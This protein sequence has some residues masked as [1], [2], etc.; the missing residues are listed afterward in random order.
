MVPWMQQKDDP[1]ASLRISM[2]IGPTS[3]SSFPKN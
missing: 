3:F 1:N 2:R